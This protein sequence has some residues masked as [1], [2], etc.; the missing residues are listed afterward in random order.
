MVAQLSDRSGTVDEKLGCEIGTY[1]W[2]Q[3]WCPDI[4]IPHLYGSA[5]LITAT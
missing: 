4:Y 5:S 2:M 3:D 1:T